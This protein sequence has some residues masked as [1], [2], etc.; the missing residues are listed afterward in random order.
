MNKQN[1]GLVNVAMVGYYNTLPFLFGLEKSNQFNLI[2]DIPSKCIEYYING[3]ADIAL[4]PVATLLERNDYKI[5]SKYCIGCSGEVG[6]VCVFSNSPISEVTKIYLDQDSR[7]SQKL[8]EVLCKRHWFINPKL[9]ECNVRNINS[10]DLNP[11]EGVLMIGDKV[12]SA[13]KSF[14]YSYDLG[15]EW[16]THSGLPFTFAV[17]IAREDV[18]DDVIATLNLEIGKGVNNMEKVLKQNKSLATKIKLD[19][20]FKKYIDYRFDTEK[21][22]ALQL[23]FDYNQHEM[24]IP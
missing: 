14:N 8:V 24:P 3:E 18:N 21:Q 23:F 13:D 5:I 20:Y 1:N 6:T 12:F 10:S 4:V 9:E 22:K 7:T 2:L 19:E 11:D 16:N 15:A 17:W